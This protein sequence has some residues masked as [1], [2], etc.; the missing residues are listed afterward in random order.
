VKNTIFSES[1]IKNPY[2]TIG[3]EE[4]EK[5]RKNYLENSIKPND[6][7]IKILCRNFELTLDRKIQACGSY[8]KICQQLLY[9]KD[10]FESQICDENDI[11]KLMPIFKESHRLCD[12]YN[13]NEENIIS[14]S[15]L[16]VQ[17]NKIVP[18]II[19]AFSVI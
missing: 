7:Q 14:S 4:L 9:E 2:K 11:P 15:S 18:N 10:D 13:K 8:S 12:L 17:K 16:I 6:N 19:P 5:I 3:N 1:I